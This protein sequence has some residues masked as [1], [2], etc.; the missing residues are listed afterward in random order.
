MAKLIK[1]KPEDLLN[2]QSGDFAHFVEDGIGINDVK[3]F[4]PRHRTNNIHKTINV[5]VL[6]LTL[7]TVFSIAVFVSAIVTGFYP[8]SLLLFLSLFDLRSV[9]RI[10]LPLNKSDFI[11]YRNI[12]EVKLIKGRL[13]FNYAHIIIVDDQGTK[14][15]K[16]IKL[17]D[18]KSGWDRAV[19]LFR[20]IG[21]LNYN[22]KQLKPI[23]DLQRITVGNGIEYAVDGDQLLIVENNR[24]NEERIDPFK[25]FRFVALVGFIGVFGA[26]LIKIYNIVVNHQYYI[27]DFMVVLFF[28]LLALIPLRFVRK[29]KPTVLKKSD[30]KGFQITKK[31]FIIRIRGWK[32]FTL[33]VEHHLKFFTQEGIKKLKQFLES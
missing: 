25:Y 27:I 7:N 8:L 21:K 20:R 23:N 33:H 15:L 18:S 10:D 14:S 9:Q 11:P 31:R 16:K 30:V 26:S 3:T 19:F 13:G 22:E 29:T 24:F 32:G 28:I 12:E 2:L 6:R 17:Y 5:R 4:E 1:T